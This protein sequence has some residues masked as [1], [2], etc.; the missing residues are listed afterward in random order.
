MATLWL[1]SIATKKRFNLGSAL[2]Q[3]RLASLGWHECSLQEVDESYV[4]TGTRTHRDKCCYSILYCIIC[5]RVYIIIYIYMYVIIPSEFL[6]CWSML[7]LYFVSAPSF[8]L[9]LYHFYPF[10]VLLCTCLMDAGCLADG[11]D[12]VGWCR[13]DIAGAAQQSSGRG[14]R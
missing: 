11:A 6:P 12:A 8:L 4:L 3:R 2:T 10:S 13:R 14:L 1:L 7:W 5:M 9:W